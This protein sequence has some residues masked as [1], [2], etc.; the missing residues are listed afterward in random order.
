MHFHDNQL[1]FIKE[2]PSG[3]IIHSVANKSEPFAK[4]Q[5]RYRDLI[6]EGDLYK[7]DN[8][9]MLIIYC[10]KCLNLLVIKEGQK[11]ISWDGKNLNVSPIRCTWESDNNK[12]VG[13]LFG[14]NLCNWNVGI[15][16]NIAKDHS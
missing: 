16:N 13:T 4:P 10:P 2:T 12:Q 8:K 1:N 3:A 14:I 5:I 6:L 15:D 7:T 11:Q 9:L